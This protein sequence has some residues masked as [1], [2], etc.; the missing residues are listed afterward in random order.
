MLALK[1]IQI[2]GLLGQTCKGGPSRYKKQSTEQYSGLPSLLREVKVCV[3][4]Y[5]YMQVS[6]LEG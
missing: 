2:F 3:V 4:I 6:Y 1:Y 5:P